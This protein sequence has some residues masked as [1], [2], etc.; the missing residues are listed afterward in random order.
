MPDPS[1][2]STVFHRREHSLPILPHPKTPPGCLLPSLPS[3]PQT[4]A[5]AEIGKHNSLACGACTSMVRLV[6]LPMLA[7]LLTGSCQC[8]LQYICDT[9]GPAQAT[10]IGL[11]GSF[12]CAISS[13]L[14]LLLIPATHT[15]L[16]ALLPSSGSSFITLHFL[17]SCHQIYIVKYIFIL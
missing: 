3:Y 17:M 12:D 14:P 13:F 15:N 10:C 1:P 4:I 7:S 8:A 9:F 2:P 6:Q 16:F 5:L 11:S